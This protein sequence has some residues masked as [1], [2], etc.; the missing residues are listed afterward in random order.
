MHPSLL[1]E[2]CLLDIA[3]RRLQRGFF[4]FERGPALLQRDPVTPVA[5]P[6]RDILEIPIT[7]IVE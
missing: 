6:A 5:D 3:A 7:K 2:I 4:L 1:F